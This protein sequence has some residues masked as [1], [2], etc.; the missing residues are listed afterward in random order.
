M[1]ASGKQISAQHKEEFGV[2]TTVLAF[3]WGG[4]LPV[5]A[6]IHAEAG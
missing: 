4:E 5:T 6:G 3:M 1:G 2:I